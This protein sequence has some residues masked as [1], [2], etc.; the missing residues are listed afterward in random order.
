MDNATT[1]EERFDS[2]TTLTFVADAMIGGFENP[3]EINFRGTTGLNELSASMR[4]YPNPVAQG[5]QISINLAAQPVRIEIL[6]ALGEVV[7]VENEIQQPINI[8]APTTPGVYTV[9]VITE[10]KGVVSHKIIV[11]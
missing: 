11:K 10:S 9:R 4:L 5:E 8:A 1:D 6:N 7:V 2:E 3:F